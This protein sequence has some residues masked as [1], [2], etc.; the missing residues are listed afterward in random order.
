[1]LFGRVVRDSDA[2]GVDVAVCGD[3]CLVVLLHT[4]YRL[5]TVDLRD[6]R[7]A[8]LLLLLLVDVVV[9]RDTVTFDWQLAGG[10]LDACHCGYTR[11]SLCLL[12]CNCWIDEK[13]KDIYASANETIVGK[14]PA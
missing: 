14:Q 10:L 4:N 9:A 7:L 5:G 2:S 3:E 8:L 6:W 12:A 11:P 13:N 1:M